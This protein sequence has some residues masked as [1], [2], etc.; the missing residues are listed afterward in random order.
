MHCIRPCSWKS[1]TEKVHNLLSLT[2]TGENSVF[3]LF[4]L[5]LQ[6]ST[7]PWAFF[8][9]FTN[10]N[11]CYY[12]Q[13]ISEY[14]C[15]KLH[16][17]ASR[18][19]QLLC[20]ITD[21]ISVALLR[22]LLIEP[23]LI[24]FSRSDQWQANK[25]HWARREFGLQIG[26]GCGGVIF[27]DQFVVSGDME[28]SKTLA[29]SLSLSVCQQGVDSPSGCNDPGDVGSNPEAICHSHTHVHT[30]INAC[31]LQRASF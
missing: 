10:T 2:Y 1:P 5:N 18:T 17:Q 4:L 26:W 23:I 30:P 31:S 13:E 19:L 3:P 14:K 7:L 25:Q 9:L 11:V 27:L 15:E 28:A 12:D 20:T 6:T 22:C 21:L 24:R 16:L 8:H 29:D